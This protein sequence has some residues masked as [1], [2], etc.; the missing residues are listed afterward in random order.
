MPVQAAQPNDAFYHELPESADFADVHS[1]GRTRA[2]PDDWIAIA[3]DVEDSTVAI[4]EGRYK[5]VTVAGAVGTIAVANVTGT[6]EFPYFFGGDG[7]VFLLPGRYRED[8][9][10]VLGDVRRVVREI[11]GLTLRVGLVSVGRLRAEGHTLEVG[12]VRVTD[13]YTQAVAF[14]SALSALDRMLK[15]PEDTTVERP[16]PRPQPGAPTAD[17][18]GFSCRWQ[19]IPSLRGETI[20]LIV[21]PQSDDDTATISRVQQL[22]GGIAGEDDV[23][24]PLTV[25]AQQTRAARSSAG[26]EAD[27]RGRGRSGLLV[28]WHRLRIHIEVA[29]VRFVM[30][31]RLPVRRFGKLLRDVRLDNIRNA[32]IRKIDGTLKTTLSVDRAVRDELVRALDELHRE[33]AIWYGIHVSDRAIMT[34]LIHTNSEDEVHFVDAAAGGYALAARALKAQMAADGGS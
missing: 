33:G 22:I 8:V 6:L 17:F 9:L 16:P 15:D 19:D 23:A 5:D 11:S 31:S 1:A 30:W 7:M 12:R 13:R 25:P 21:R 28:W 29:A 4:E 32:D 14:G 27:Y 10:A 18:K 24:H 20:S 3:T 34:C 2:V 26:A